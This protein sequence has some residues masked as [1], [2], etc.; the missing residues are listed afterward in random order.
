MAGALV[1]AACPFGWQR[2]TTV[3]H[4]HRE[5]LRQS[6]RT[7]G[8]PV[9]M[10]RLPLLQVPLPWFW[11]SAF[12]VLARDLLLL[13]GFASVWIKASSI[14]CLPLPASEGV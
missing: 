10:T 2:P 6:L 1:G 14:S 5:H 11:R 4:W 8:H 13:L 12:R 3:S 7:T 9:L